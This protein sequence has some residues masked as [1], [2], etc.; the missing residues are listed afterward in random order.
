MKSMK[1]F[2]IFSLVLVLAMVTNSCADFL[3]EQPRS[4]LTPDFFTTEQ[5]IV[6]GL[7]AA[8][9]GL[10]FQYGTQ[11]GMSIT[12]VGTDEGNKGGD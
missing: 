8:Y 9:S 12:C 1:T 10:R 11:G 2:K 4:S 6:S 7:T 3:E 5:G